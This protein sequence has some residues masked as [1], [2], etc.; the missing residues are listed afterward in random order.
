MLCRNVRATCL[1]I[2]LVGRRGAGSGK[3][4]NCMS[5]QRTCSRLGC[6]AHGRTSR[7]ACTDSPQRQTMSRRSCECDSQ[8]STDK[9]NPSRRAVETARAVAVGRA[10]FT[11]CAKPRQR[12]AHLRTGACGGATAAAAGWGSAVGSSTCGGSGSGAVFRHSVW[13]QRDHPFPVAAKGWEVEKVRVTAPHAH[14]TTYSIQHRC[15]HRVM[16]FMHCS[17]FQNRTQAAHIG[18][19]L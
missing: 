17:V 6:P 14:L 19:R 16:P 8:G 10:A 1:K 9:H 3:Q 15:R 11:A 12:P 4:G 18:H 5:E 7:A 2:S 13:P